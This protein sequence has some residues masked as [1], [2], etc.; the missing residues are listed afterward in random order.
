MTAMSFTDGVPMQR[1]RTKSHNTC[2]I[3]RGTMRGDA[4]SSP[5]VS[6]IERSKAAVFG[7]PVSL[8]N[9]M[10]RIVPHAPI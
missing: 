1:L 6:V 10:Q 7:S 2:R 3:A 5:L 4:N 9:L 8:K